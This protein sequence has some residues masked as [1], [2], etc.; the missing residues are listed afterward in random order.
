M[1]A[2]KQIFEK[3]KGTTG[4]LQSNAAPGGTG[5]GRPCGQAHVQQ[6][7]LHVPRKLFQFGVQQL[8]RVSVAVSPKNLV[9]CQDV[10]NGKRS[11]RIDPERIGGGG[12]KRR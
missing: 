12:E 3:E 2:E 11:K 8:L 5:S 4:T 10:Q 6:A 7:Y 9:H 1:R